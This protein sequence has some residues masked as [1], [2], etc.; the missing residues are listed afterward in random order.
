MRAQTPET[1][2]GLD[3]PLQTGER[4]VS[5]LVLMTQSR[6]FLAP[7]CRPDAFA[8]NCGTAADLKLASDSCALAGFKANSAQPK[9]H[10]CLG[11]CAVTGH[12]EDSD[13]SSLAHQ[14][15]PVTG[16]LCSIPLRMPKPVTGKTSHAAKPVSVIGR[17][18][19]PVT[20]SLCL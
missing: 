6:G 11:G 17:V 15:C 9:A 1:L 16:T 3:G 13:I 4:E 8:N 7:C 10:I 2:L 12:T 20:E 5:Y 19:V 18:C 14:P